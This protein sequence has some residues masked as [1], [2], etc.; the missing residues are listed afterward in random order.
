[1]SERV[2][3]RFRATHGSVVV[4]VFALSCGVIL[5]YRLSMLPPREVLLGCLGVVLCL[6]FRCRTPLLRGFVF[7]VFTLCLGLSWA[8]WN[9]GKRLSERLPADFEGKILPV[10]GYLC[11]IPS[12]GSFG[13]L[14]F[15][16]CV[17]RW[18]GVSE[19]ADMAGP[20]PKKLRLA[21]YQP[22]TGGLPGQRLRLEVVLKRPYG[23]L[24]P[25]GFRFEDWLFR[26]GYRATGTVRSV[27]ADT[28]VLC[29]LNCHYHELHRKLV[30][31]VGLHF[32]E[33]R[34]FP[35]VASLL[36][37]YRGYL[38][39]T[40]WQVFRATGTVHLVA[41][42]GLHLGLIAVISGYGFRWLLLLIPAGR[43]S[44]TAVRR[45]VYALVV[46][47]CS[48]YALAAGFTVPT[49]RALIMVTVAGWILLCARQAPPWLALA[50]ALAVVLVTDPFAPLDPG[51]WLSF[52]AVS[53]L[54]CVFAGYSG[55]PGWFRGLVLAQFAVF[56]GLWP[57]L[58]LQGQNQPLAGAM[59]NLAAIPWVSLVVMP[60]LVSGAALVVLIPGAAVMVVP[61]FDGVLGVLW[62]FLE[63][64]A[65]LTVPE[66]QAGFAEVCVFAILGLALVFVPLLWF[67]VVGALVVILW[68]LSGLL[69]TDRGNDFVQVPEVRVLDVG[70]GLSV[71]VRHGDRVLLYD[72]GPEIP[73]VFSAAESAIVPSLRALGVR[74]INTLVISH[75][76]RDHSGGL[77][78]LV[79][80]M[81]PGRILSGEP[82]RIGS[83]LE[84]GLEIPVAGCPDDKEM[85]GDLHIHY[86]QWP[87]AG[88]D[89]DASCVVRVWHPDSSSEWIIPGDIGVYAEAAYLD[90][91]ARALSE[92]A[93][94]VV[95]AP[96][97][98]S[99]TSSSGRWTEE[100]SPDVVIYSAGYRHRFGHPHP[101]VTA[102]YRQV[103]ALALNTACSGMI[104]MFAEGQGLSL[105]EMRHSVPF[106]IGA[107]GLMRDQCTIP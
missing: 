7:V 18:H 22:D 107:R 34:Q 80:A 83:R 78:Y 74:H 5:L 98:G 20:L 88:N 40:D 45:L 13:S 39:D 95:V 73:G 42:S 99:K 19:T 101:D 25:A 69:S 38:S 106:W 92:P 85:I 23:A 91:L 87:L 12:E 47:A 84:A 82:E 21:W 62:R 46:V 44:E 96:H 68:G 59:A 93:K 26:K 48:G 41:I 54:L 52:G 10:S 55:R 31:W 77:Q 14:R 2:T 76:D 63:W 70:Q 24:N 103:G 81:K 75:S 64:V 4:A 51:F 6:F 65:R 89:N 43:V 94:R 67:R 72:T 27:T 57:V 66:L 56:A 33:A 1:M 90:D 28:E 15:S 53:V 11:D 79:K 17:T 86:W 97:H 36:V 58:V 50:V 102:R 35:L 100:L 30:D 105:Q 104:S 3:R 71:L 37:G 29:G 61:V 8:A 60:I 49:R 9:A 16:L 32:R